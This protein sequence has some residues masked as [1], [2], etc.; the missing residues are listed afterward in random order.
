MIESLFAEPQSVFAAI[1][2]A[3]KHRAFGCRACG[4][5]LL[6][7]CAY[8]CPMQC[9]KGLRNGPCGGMVNGSCEVYPQSPCIWNAIHAKRSD[10]QWHE[11]MRQPAD[12]ELFGTSSWI[13]LFT[14]KDRPG[15]VPASLITTSVPEA[16]NSA[17]FNAASK[18][19]AITV[20]LRTPRF[21][22]QKQL[23][24]RINDAHTLKD[25]VDAICVTS[26][27]GAMAP[28]IFCEHLHR[29]TG[30]PTIIPLVGRDIGPGEY[31]SALAAR[32]QNAGAVGVL[33]LSGDY[34]G[35]APFPM[36]SAQVLVALRNMDWKHA[37]PQFGAALHV[38]AQPR[39]AALA[40]AAQKAMA[41]AEIFFSQMILGDEGVA[42]F[43]TEMRTIPALKEIPIVMGIPL[44]GTEHGFS[45]LERLPGVD[46][47]LPFMA[48]FRAS[49]DVPA[50]GLA[51]ACQSV[52][53]ARS[54]RG[55]G[56]VGVHVMPF[57][58]SALDTANWIRSLEI[59]D[60]TQRT[61]Q[62]QGVCK[63]G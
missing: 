6:T 27:P 31:G 28:E 33:S 50:R 10:T 56:V 2:I 59:P 43:I 19:L 30:V 38:Q 22:S 16:S 53:L 20:E 62:E 11:T 52:E 42:E 12:P 61:K 9:P 44:I 32:L 4:Q 48:R 25:V 54:L 34:A 57:G 24:H 37:R 29:E 51:A 63:H 8:V 14:G 36:D 23:T 40:R 3:I 35:V 1:E 60:A 41:G 45:V 21:N 55:L 18:G 47:S 13:N 39:K 17:L 7:Q 49:T 26:H 46:R 15:R 5:C 58:L